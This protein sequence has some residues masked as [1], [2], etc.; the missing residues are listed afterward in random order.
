MSMDRSLTTRILLAGAIALAVP[1]AVQARPFSGERC[2]H[3][4]HGGPGMH[5][6]YGDHDRHGGWDR[7]D[8]ERL[9]RMLSNLD[10][11]AAQRD[12]V[13]EL[14]RAQAD[15]M[16]D[17]AAALRTVHE[18]LRALPLSPD[19]SE[20][21]V[22]ALAEASGRA[23]AEMAELRVRTARRIHELLTPEQRKALEERHERRAE[24]RERRGPAGESSGENR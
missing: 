1:L 8:G 10:L 19:Y 24:W 17:K 6:M 14:V 3:D 5:G 12:Q 4:K 18:E 7:P 2:D 9:P 11:S 22:K 23:A 21:K 15:A 13:R 20:A 16:R